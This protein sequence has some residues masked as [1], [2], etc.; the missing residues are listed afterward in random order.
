M[1][2]LRP[3]FLFGYATAA[4]QIEGGGQDKED[5][6]GR[7]RSVS[8]IYHIKL[9]VQ[10]WDRFCDK[11]D[12]IEDGSHVVRSTNFLE[13]YKEDIARKLITV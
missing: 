3:D 9:S 1:Q 13:N 10:I 7:G 2:G 8:S 6:S 12:A 4:A 5:A 11:P